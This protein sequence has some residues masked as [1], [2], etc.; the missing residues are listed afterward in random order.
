MTAMAE[1]AAMAAAMA[2]AAGIRPRL[3]T[4]AKKET[5]GDAPRHGQWSFT[6]RR[7]AWYAVAGV[8]RCNGAAEGSAYRRTED[9]PPRQTIAGEQGICFLGEKRVVEGDSFA[10]R[11]AGCG[12]F[13]DGWPRGFGHRHLRP[14]GITLAAA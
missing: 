11:F 12:R 7:A 3:L 9:G 6:R 14:A 13:S 5:I 4:A 8:K 10:P 1:V 2:A